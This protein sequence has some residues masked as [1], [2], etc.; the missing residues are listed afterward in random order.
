MN[1]INLFRKIRK[2]SLLKTNLTEE[3]SGAIATPIH[4]TSL[5]VLLI[6]EI[7]ET[8][9]LHLKQWF[10]GSLSNQA[11]YVRLAILGKMREANVDMLSM[12]RVQKP[13]ILEKTM[14]GCNRA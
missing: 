4:S 7:C 10:N 6:T 2:S 1:L 3:Y 12:I 11:L 5:M 8:K 13:G 14:D 9:F